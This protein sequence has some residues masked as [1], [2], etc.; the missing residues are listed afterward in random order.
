MRSK[1]GFVLAF[2]VAAGLL[3]GCAP[4]TQSP[5]RTV[6]AFDRDSDTLTAALQEELSAAAARWL[7]GD[8][9]ELALGGGFGASRLLADRR[10]VSIH[11]ATAVQ[12]ALIARGVPHDEIVISDGCPMFVMLPEHLRVPTPPDRRRPF[13]IVIDP[14]L[15]SENDYCPEM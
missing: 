9:V 10:A 6:I 13:R 1:S 14:P 12:D 2:S 7:A 11:R 5:A 4:T 3:V 15:Y 8:D